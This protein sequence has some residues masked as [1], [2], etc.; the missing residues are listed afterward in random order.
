MERIATQ[1]GEVYDEL[2]V[3]AKVSMAGQCER[4]SEC[5]LEKMTGDKLPGLTPNGLKGVCNCGLI[6]EMDLFKCDLLNNHKMRSS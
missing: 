3:P 4:I 5:L 6:W 2:G 1:C